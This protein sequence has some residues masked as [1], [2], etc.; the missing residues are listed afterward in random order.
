MN[1]IEQLL[2]SRYDELDLASRGVPRPVRSLIVTPRFPESRHVIFLVLDSSRVALVAKVARRPWDD[3]GIRAEWELLSSLWRRAPVLRGTVPEALA[4]G[5]W[6]GL[7]YLLETSV[8]GQT[9][10]HRHYRRRPRHFLAA[11][12]QWLQALPITA[13]GREDPGWY[14][15]LLTE[16][17]CQLEHVLE[18]DAPERA[19]I[20]A[21]RRLLE[22]LSGIDIPLVFEHGDPMAPNLLWDRQQRRIGLIDWELGCERGL[23]GHD[24]ALFLTFAAIAATNSYGRKRELEAYREALLAPSG[25]A[26]Q[27]LCRHLDGIGLEIGLV[28]PLLLACAAR[29][30]LQLFP[31]LGVAADRHA[32]AAAVRMFRQSRNAGM[33]R[34][35]AQTLE[36]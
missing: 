18:A 7:P 23:P 11:F 34:M 27:R 3:G 9:L 5:E 17:L 28:A 32:A 13:R 35:A 22:P 12:E 16:P 2:E 33:W 15:R 14:E 29:F 6:G 25:W 24:A 30:A 8:P 10:S 36:T 19:L 31:R 20:V 21:T 26:R 4:Y 1:L